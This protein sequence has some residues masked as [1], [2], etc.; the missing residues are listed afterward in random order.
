M[1]KNTTLKR[2][3]T[4]EVK[5]ILFIVT[6]VLGVVKPY[7]N[8]EKDIALI[9][10]NHYTH[11]ENLQVEIKEL[12]ECDTELRKQYIELLKVISENK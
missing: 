10:E 8:I 2:W 9:K 1:D 12:K 11:I 4:T 5:F 7:Y 3:L 6:I